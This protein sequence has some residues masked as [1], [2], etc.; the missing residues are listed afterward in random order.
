MYSLASKLPLAQHLFHSAP[1]WNHYLLEGSRRNRSENIMHFS[2]IDVFGKISWPQILQGHGFWDQKGKAFRLKL[3]SV[4]LWSLPW[5]SKN[6]RWFKELLDFLKYSEI[7]KTTIYVI[8]HILTF[9]HFNPANFIMKY[10][11]SLITSNYIDNFLLIIS[12][13]S[14]YLT[15]CLLD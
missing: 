5:I 6:T 10:T 12:N 9:K 7:Q 8:F 2:H 3:L 15:L 1:L 14:L 11:L 4:K 13:F